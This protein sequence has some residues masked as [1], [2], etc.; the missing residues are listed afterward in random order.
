MISPIEFLGW[1]LLQSLAIGT[2]LVAITDVV[3]RA[4]RTNILL[5]FIASVLALG[6]LG[7]ACFWLA[8]ANYAL[9]SILKVIFFAVIL[10]RLVMMVREKRVS[11]YRW[12]VEPLLY[13]FLFFVAVISL[14]FSNGG[15]EDPAATAQSRFNWKLHPDNVLPFFFAD[16]L[17]QGRVPTPVL[18]TWLGSDRPPLQS[19]I[20]LLLALKTDQLTYQIVAS[21]M[22]ATFLF[23]VWLFAK[24]AELGTFTRR[25]VL[26]SS[27]LLP[28]TIC[29]TFFTWPKLLSSGYLLFA[30]TL[31]F[32]YRRTPEDNKIIGVLLGGSAALAMLSHG[33][34]AFVLLA[35]ATL[36]VLTW[37]WPPWASTLRFG[38]TFIAL[39]GPWVAYQQFIDPPGNRLIKWYLAGSGDVDSRSV[40][41]TLLDS[42]S[43]L[44]WQEYVSGRIENFAKMIGTWPHHLWNI[45]KLTF[46]H[47]AKL[48][49]AV[50]K[51]DF[52]ELL[53]SLHF[54]SVAVLLALSLLPFC[55]GREFRKTALLLIGTFGII[56]V[57]FAV[58]IFEPGQT[59]NHQTTYTLQILATIFAFSVLASRVPLIALLIFALQSVTI[60]TAYVLMIP[61]DV[62]VWPLWLTG[63]LAS[64]LLLLY[65]FSKSEHSFPKRN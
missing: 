65:S 23:G 52:F 57:I 49:A 38:V 26:L 13:T 64:L 50:T 29:H 20:Y 28:A 30:F 32:V 63:A 44:T 58:L 4:L 15:F 34:A 36:V 48:E 16:L 47:D 10:L 31:L 8:F 55:N 62:R 40:L 42:Y 22:Q 51:S 56:S 53:P 6:V 2:V 60:L 59:I 11:S 43:A 24:A 1:L 46:Q 19:G 39:Y 35:L 45:T 3:Q 18:G 61:H 14:G 37:K 7:Y 27:C 41:Q 25:C 54:H 5:T 33:S 21:W 17:K 9:F 12:T